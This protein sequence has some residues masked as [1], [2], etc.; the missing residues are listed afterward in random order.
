M[1]LQRCKFIPIL[2]FVV[3]ASLTS[4]GV[5][6]ADLSDQRA[7]EFVTALQH[8][9]FDSAERVCSALMRAGMPQIKEA[10]QKEIGAFGRLESFEVT[11][12]S[13]T[14]GVQVRIVTLNFERPSGLAAQIAV[15]GRGDVSGLYFVAAKASPETDKLADDRVNEMVQGLRD[16]KF[17]VAEAH[18]DSTMKSVLGPSA[19]EQAWKQRT[20][21]LGALTAWRI[22]GR[23][24]VSGSL[25][26]LVNIDFAKAPKAF[27]LRIAVDLSGE[28]GGLYFVEAQN[29]AT[30]NS[31]DPPYVRLGAFK[32]RDITIGT[33]DGPLG[34]T[35]TIPT[36]TG[37]FPGAV[38]VHGSGPND[39]DERIFANRPFRD[40]AEGL[41]S[42]GI[43]VL[44]YD[45]RTRVYRR[46]S[47]DITVDAEVIDDAVAALDLIKREPEV[48]PTRVFVVGHSLGAMLA[49]EIAAR[50]KAAG[51]IM[52][53]PSG[54]PLPDTIV[55][56]SRYLG[57]SQQ[58]LAQSEEN[59]RLLRTKALPPQQTVA[60]TGVPASYFYDLASHQEIAYAQ[61]LGRPIL[62][63]HGARDYQVVDDDINVWRKGLKGVPNVTIEEFP[64]LNHLFISGSG[65]P[66]PDEYLV[67]S[68]VAPQVI[69]RISSFI[70][71]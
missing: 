34:G 40:I 23:G 13:S 17:D 60:G 4:K 31:L 3:T 37:P 43:V 42:S 32:A 2:L 35:I 19:L 48:D 56:Q 27:A 52:L 28:I 5:A 20:A 15:D 70:K 45:K 38:L 41:S 50:G 66:S 55:R 63:L 49:P 69:S 64:D 53:A 33:P 1:N 44:R 54:V 29:E 30:A 65:R 9:D 62:I 26:R 21:S 39:R 7:T 18:F 11:G 6:L 68:Y 8:N 25:V 47:E 24:E 58:A 16:H 59:A 10:W 67:A 51:A 12:R 46:P 71:Q 22:V 14:N 57:T 36:G 61:K